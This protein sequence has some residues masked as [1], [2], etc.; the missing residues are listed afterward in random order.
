M[1]RWSVTERLP[2]IDLPAL[3]FVGGRDLI[4][5]DHAGEA[6]AAA[7]PQARLMRVEDAGHMG[8]V[9]KAAFY[10]EQ[11]ADFADFIGLLRSRADSPSRR[12]F[13]SPDADLAPPARPDEEPEGRGD[14]DIRAAARPIQARRPAP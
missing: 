4:T 2:E 6:I 14:P 9:E 12:S 3:V 8:P 7:L 5:T 1:L 11:I 13:L 10:N